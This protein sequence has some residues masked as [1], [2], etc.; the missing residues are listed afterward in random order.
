MK[1]ITKVQM[2]RKKVKVMMKVMIKVRK[3][4]KVMKMRFHGKGPKNV[5]HRRK[6]KHNS[7]SLFLFPIGLFLIILSPRPTLSSSAL[8]WECLPVASIPGYSASKKSS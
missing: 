1:N 2:M 6:Q 3:K 8:T 7:Q 4:M 5:S